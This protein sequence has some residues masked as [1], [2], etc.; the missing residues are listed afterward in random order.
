MSVGWGW[1]EYGQLGYG[2]THN[3]GDNEHPFKANNV[4]IGSKALDVQ[5]SYQH[6]CALLENKSVKCWGDR[7][8]IGPGHTQNIGDNEL[9][10]SI[11]SIN[12]G[13]EVRSVQVSRAVG[14]AAT[15]ALMVRGGL[16]CWGYQAH[17]WLGIN[18]PESQANNYSGILDIPL[19]GNISS[20]SL[21]HRYIHVLLKNSHIKSWGR[22]DSGQ[23]GLGH[24]EH[25]GDNELSTYAGSPILRRRRQSHHSQICP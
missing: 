9:P 10:S 17:Q 20:F 24:T 14:Y 21:G 22:N 8:A 2:H 12:L 4:S 18:V 7:H 23:L 16:K 5:A 13:S 1:N 19:L 3:V 25:I 11:A 6:T 15:C